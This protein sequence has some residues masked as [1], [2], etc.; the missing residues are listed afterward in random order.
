MSFMYGA[1]LLSLFC[2]AYHSKLVLIIYMFFTFD[3]SYNLNIPN[4][5]LS[6]A[7]KRPVP[8]EKLRQLQLNSQITTLLFTVDNYGLIKLWHY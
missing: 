1:C 2:L 3:D 4:K 7:M 5:P 6:H 8:E